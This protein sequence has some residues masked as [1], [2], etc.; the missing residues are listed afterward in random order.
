MIEAIEQVAHAA[1][2]DLF[3]TMLGCALEPCPV[4]S[5]VISEP[6][7][8]GA[9]GLVGKMTG[10]VYLYLTASFARRATCQLLGVR[11]QDLQGDEL[12]N[13]AVGELAN[14]IVGQLKTELT[15]RGV[16]CAVTVP[17]VVRGNRFS[18]STSNAGGR[19]VLPFRVHLHPEVVVEV[20]VKSLELA[21]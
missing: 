13:D 5:V 21:A 12:I 3:S 20:F 11:D 18:I 8:A 17:S 16:S 14:I 4:T 7:I 9:V 6:H 15:N 1:V 10:V 2:T 19:V